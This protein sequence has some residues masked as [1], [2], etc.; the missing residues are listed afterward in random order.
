[1]SADPDMS[2]EEL[3][4]SYQETVDVEFTWIVESER[5]LDDVIVK[6]ADVGI[7]I[8]P[9]Q[10]ILVADWIVQQQENIPLA[11]RLAVLREMLSSCPAP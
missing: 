6:L 5:T 7:T 10:R 11:S 8:E 4:H 9:W 3:E 1:M 2:E